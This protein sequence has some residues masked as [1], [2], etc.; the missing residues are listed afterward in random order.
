MSDVAETSEDRRHRVLRE[1][2]E[3]IARR[4]ETQDVEKNLEIL[5]FQL[6]SES[7]AVGRGPDERLEAVPNKKTVCRS[8][9][10]LFL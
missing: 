4:P 1:R 8:V 7:Y 6:L 3:R 2:A 5:V 9:S 10:G